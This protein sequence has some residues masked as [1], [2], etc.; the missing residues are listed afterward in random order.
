M[1]AMAGELF[2]RIAP[3]LPPPWSDELC[4]AILCATFPLPKSPYRFRISLVVM[5]ALSLKKL[6]SFRMD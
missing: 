1:R 4:W 5:S 3:E 2:P 6:V